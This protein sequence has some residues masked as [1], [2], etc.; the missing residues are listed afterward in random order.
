MHQASE[1][2]DKFQQKRPKGRSFSRAHLLGS[3]LGPT[4]TTPPHPPPRD[5]VSLLSFLSPYP[6]AHRLPTL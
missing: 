3:W 6:E 2:T 1:D 4:V 5:A